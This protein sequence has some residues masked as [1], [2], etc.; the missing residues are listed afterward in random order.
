M[1]IYP[2][3]LSSNPSLTVEAFRPVA[4]KSL[5]FFEGIYWL[6]SIVFLNI[7]IALRLS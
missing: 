5:K 4:Y 6:L 2:L 1:A 7:L 3:Q